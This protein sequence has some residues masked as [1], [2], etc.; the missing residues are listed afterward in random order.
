MPVPRHMDTPG[1]ASQRSANR[2]YEYAKARGGKTNTFVSLHVEE[3]AFL[4]GQVT[5]AEST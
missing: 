1:N 4:Q 2:Y 5:E 3:T